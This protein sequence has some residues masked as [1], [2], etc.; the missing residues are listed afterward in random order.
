MGRFD[1]KVAFITGAARGQG[2]SHAL[3]LAQEG[4]DIIAVDLCGPV[5]TVPY[6]LGTEDDL[7]ET[8]RLV[9]EYDRRAYIQVADVRDSAALR[10]A[11]G[12]GFAELGRIDIVLC[13][14]G[15]FSSSPP[16]EMPDEMWDEMIDVNLTGV[17]KTMKAT[18]PFILQGGRGGAIAATSSVAGMR[19]SAGDS[20][21]YGAAKYA[22]THLVHS[23]ALNWGPDRIR[24]N[25]VAPTNCN[26][27]MLHSQAMYDLFRP[28][29]EGPTIDDVRPAF[30]RS[31]ILPDM[32]WVEPA[33]ITAAMLWLCSDEARFVTGVVLPVDGGNFIKH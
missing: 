18:V 15:I 31:Q 3:R 19:G 26:T 10:D 6:A 24:V 30:A 27:D 22:L 23:M 2:R 5:K 20:M 12:N 1:G 14:A 33:D 17:W 16:L 13:N 32:P 7:R 9:E 4:A 11:A 25:A 28:D 8:A 29:I 21:H